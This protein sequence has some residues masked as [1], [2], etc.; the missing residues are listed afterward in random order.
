MVAILVNCVFMAI[1]DPTVDEAADYQVTV[2]HREA[3]GVQQ[4]DLGKAFP[5]REK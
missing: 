5:A 3:Q 4:A 1:A 2:S